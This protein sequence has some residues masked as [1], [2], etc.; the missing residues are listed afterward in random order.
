MHRNSDSVR[1]HRQSLK[2]RAFKL[3]GAACVWCGSEE[4]VE[5]A[6][7]IPTGI[8]GEGRGLDRRYRDVVNNPSAY[9]PMCRSHHRLF[10]KL[11]KLG[12]ARADEPPAGEEPIPF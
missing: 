6:H 7:V 10:D 1:K 3:I 11:V 4:R 12:L 2:R 8:K 9:R 5:A